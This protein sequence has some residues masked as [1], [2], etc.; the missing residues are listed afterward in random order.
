M[1]VFQQVKHD[2][3]TGWIGPP[4]LSDTLG[5]FVSSVASPTSQDGSNPLMSEK[6]PV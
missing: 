5:I 4:S 1:I 6:K 2:L 3:D